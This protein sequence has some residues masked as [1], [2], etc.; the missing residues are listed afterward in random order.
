MQFLGLDWARW[1]EP[2][3]NDYLENVD[4]AFG[5][6]EKSLRKNNVSEL[7]RGLVAGG[8]FKCLA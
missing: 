6:I 1:V 3:V 2:L 5:A 4:E 7:L 8:E